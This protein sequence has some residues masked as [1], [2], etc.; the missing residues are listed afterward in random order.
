MT[1]IKEKNA[2][3]QKESKFSLLQVE[4]EKA[5]EFCFI[6]GFGEPTPNEALSIY[7]KHKT[8]AEE[9]KSFKAWKKEGKKIKKGSKGFLFWSRP[10]NQ[11]K[12][13]K[14]A[15]KGTLTPDLQKSLE[16][17]KS[18]FAVCY[19]FSNLQIN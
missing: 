18:N 14:E 16:S 8:G 6:N 1:N 12:I 2:I 7:Y 3:S 11:I 5:K 19:L 10:V 15:Q 13:E 9:F 17:E 4:T